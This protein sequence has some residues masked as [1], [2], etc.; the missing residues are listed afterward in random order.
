MHPSRDPLLQYN[1]HRVEPYFEEEHMMEHQT[2][3]LY[4]GEEYIEGVEQIVEEEVVADEQ[5]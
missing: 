5:V 2:E 4:P 3:Q 1:R